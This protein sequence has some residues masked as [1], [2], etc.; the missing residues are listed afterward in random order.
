ML[1]R[2]IRNGRMYLMVAPLIVMGLVIGLVTRNSLQ[3]NAKELVESYQLMNLTT[4]SLA[5]LLTQDDASKAIL[6]DPDNTASDARKIRAYDQ[7]K[8]VLREIA[9]HSKSAEVGDIVR[10]LEVLDEDVLTPLDTS[11]LELVAAGEVKAAQTQYFKHYEPARGR[12]EALL[13]K[14][15]HLAEIDADRAAQN[16]DKRNQASLRNVCMALGIGAVVVVV[17]ARQDSARRAAESANRTKSEYLAEI[18]KL[19]DQLKQENFRMSAELDVTRRLQQM[20]LPRDEDMREI[21]NLDISGF[22]EPAA[23]AMSPAMAWKAA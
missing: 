3:N 5:L 21:T 18:R 16:L 19:H 11:V 17:A 8:L 14:L 6:F 1:N 10:K 9:T 23:S 15:G 2:I 4:V 13:R 20:M 7:N 12:Y 22:M